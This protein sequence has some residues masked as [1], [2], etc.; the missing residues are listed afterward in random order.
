MNEDRM[1]NFLEETKNI[2]EVNGKT[3][4]DIK[5]IGIPGVGTISVEQFKIDADKMYY[6]G[7]GIEYVNLGLLIVGDDWWLERGEYDG[8]EW[9]EFKKSPNKPEETGQK[10]NIWYDN[11]F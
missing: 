3:F 8:S 11:R 2:L 10:V 1:T 5:W 7:F 6:P 9:W 4:D